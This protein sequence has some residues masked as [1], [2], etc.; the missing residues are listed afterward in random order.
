M[1]E[2][3][4]ECWAKLSW[5]KLSKSHTIVLILINVEFRNTQYH[6]FSWLSLK[7]HVLSRCYKHPN[8]SIQFKNTFFL[9]VCGNVFKK[10]THVG[11]SL[12]INWQTF[13][14]FNWTLAN[15]NRCLCI[16]QYVSSLAC[17]C[18]ACKQL[19]DTVLI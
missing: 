11:K 12:Y 7:N 13:C 14:M 16:I 17:K 9:G 8:T 1:F 4:I 5:V 18:P 15:T 10:Q 3:F 6:V 2:N 19:H